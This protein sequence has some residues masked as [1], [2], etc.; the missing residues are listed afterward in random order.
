M[1]QPSVEKKIKKPLLLRVLSGVMLVSKKTFPIVGKKLA[2]KLFFRVFRYPFKEDELLKLQEAELF[3]INYK[4]Q[5]LQGYRWGDPQ[6][7]VVLCMHGWSGRALQF[8]KFID[9]L[10][11]QGY[12]V[13]AFDAPGHGKSEGKYSSLMEY[14]ELILKLDSEYDFR[15]VLAHSMGGAA[16]LLSVREGLKLDKLV[17]VSPPVIP[18]LILKEFCYRL[19]A[20]KAVWNYIETRIAE[21]YGQSFESFFPEHYLPL[22]SFP[23]TLV[24]HDKGDRDVPFKNGQRLQELVPDIQLIQTEGLG[25]TRILRNDDVLAS[26]DDFLKAD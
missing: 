23:N 4:Q 9:P 26:I 17:L 5:R 13:V 24:V 25:H 2:Y 15:H 22:S 1:K 14:Q 7:E 19:G 16:S 21:E 20:G 8:W 12:C 10:L 11:A 3:D 6:G 18:S